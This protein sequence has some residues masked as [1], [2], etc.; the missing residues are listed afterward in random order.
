MERKDG[1]VLL[2]SGTEQKRKKNQKDLELKEKVK[3]NTTVEIW[4]F[5]TAVFFAVT[6]VTTIGYG[7]PVPITNIGRVVCIMFSLFGIPL[8][9]VTI[10]DLGGSDG[11][12]KFAIYLALTR[13]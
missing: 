9:L 11:V 12:A 10:A 6:V 4:S 7:N 3:R 2:Y 13:N 5:S 8:T 1:E